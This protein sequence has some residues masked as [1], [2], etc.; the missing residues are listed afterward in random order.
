MDN[1]I[2]ALA[3]NISIIYGSADGITRSISARHIIHIQFAK[4]KNEWDNTSGVCGVVK[5]VYVDTSGCADS[6]TRPFFDRQVIHNMSGGW[7]RNNDNCS[8]KPFKD[9]WDSVKRV[10]EHQNKVLAQTHESTGSS[11][12][13]SSTVTATADGFA[14]PLVARPVIHLQYDINNEVD[15]MSC[16]WS[17]KHSDI[18]SMKYEECVE[19]TSGFADSIT[20]PLASRPVIQCLTNTEMDNMSDYRQWNYGICSMKVVEQPQQGAHQ[21]ISHA[22]GF[23]RCTHQASIKTELKQKREYFTRHH[24]YNYKDTFHALCFWFYS[25]MGSSNQPNLHSKYM[26]TV[27]DYDFIGLMENDRT[28]HDSRYKASR[29]TNIWYQYLVAAQDHRIYTV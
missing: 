14:H 24:W 3:S 18:C 21:R 6:I 20:H 10:V 5:A 13:L 8:M 15:T 23:K 19:D 28:W 9:R 29:A 1:T 12:S 11:L 27:F 25:I 22:S 2:G 16:D 26:E 4:K 7:S 17:W